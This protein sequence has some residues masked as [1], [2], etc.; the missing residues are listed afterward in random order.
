MITTTDVSNILVRDCKIFGLE[1]FQEGAIPDGELTVERITVHAKRQTIETYWNKGFVEV[2][3][4]V[5]DKYG[6]ADLV[7]LNELQRIA[8]RML[9]KVGEY[10][11]THY[12]YS[13]YSSSKEEEPSL[14]CHFIN[15]R[16]L[17]EVLNIN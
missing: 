15:V 8:T 7:R 2:N 9:E 4:C 3:F 6:E 17:F 1:V 12:R 11:G 14:K 5:P 13:V 16:L 10:D